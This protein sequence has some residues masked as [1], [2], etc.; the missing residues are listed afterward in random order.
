[1][2]EAALGFVLVRCSRLARREHVLRV[3]VELVPLVAVG[4]LARD[5]VMVRLKGRDD[6][7][8]LA[9]VRVLEQAEVVACVIDAGRDQN[10]RA[11]VV[12]Q[13]RL[14]GKVFDDA[15]NNAL[16]ALAGAHQFFHRR[17]TATD[18]RLLKVVQPFCLLLKP[19]IDGRARRNLLRHI[20][21]FVLQVQN[22]LIRHRLVKL[23]GVDVGSKDIAGQLLVFA[24]ERRA[25]RASRHGPPF[26]QAFLALKR[27]A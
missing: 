3:R 24:Q 16:L 8:M 14:Q 25:G 12:I 26:R 21:G 17:P 2:D 13:A 6:A 7:A 4:R 5:R 22:H 19:R 27:L 1:V 23:V 9:E 20:A 10:R 11:P 15:R 18:K